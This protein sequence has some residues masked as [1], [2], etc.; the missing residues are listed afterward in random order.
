MRWW[1]NGYVLWERGD[2]AASMNL[3]D[4]FDQLGEEQNVALFCC[5]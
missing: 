1:R 3:E 5:S 4:L 2:V